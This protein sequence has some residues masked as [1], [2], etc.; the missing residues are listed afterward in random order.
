MKYGIYFAYWEHEWGADYHKYIDKVADLGFDILEIGCTPL[1]DWPKEKLLELKRHAA[2]RG[3]ILTGGYGPAACY[4]LAS[5]DP[6]VREN[7]KKFY[8]ELL[9]RLEIMDIHVVG[10]GL[11]SY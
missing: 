11:Y 6:A 10:G 7:G 4:N 5:S 2:D 8:R 9:S 1:N 3:I